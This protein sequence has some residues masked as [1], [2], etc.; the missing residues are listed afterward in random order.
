MHSANTILQETTVNKAKTLSRHGLNLKCFK[1]LQP[2]HYDTNFHTFV[3]M[4]LYGVT[5]YL[6]HAKMVYM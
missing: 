1:T 6:E 2:Y 4:S 5:T 3:C